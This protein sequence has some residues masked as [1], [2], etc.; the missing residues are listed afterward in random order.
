MSAQ[1][2]VRFVTH[3]A[4]IMALG[5][6]T[7][8]GGCGSARTIVAEAPTVKQS[9]AQATIAEDAATV[10]VPP[11]AKA[12][13]VDAVSKALYAESAF[14]QGQGGVKLSYRFIQFNA[15]SQFERWFWGGIGNAGEGS[16]TVEVRFLDQTGK[17]LA[18][19]QSDGR[20]GSGLF[21]GSMQDAVKRAADEVASYTKANFK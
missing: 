7:A 21:G 11:E 4:T 8:L 17:Q 18:K 10:P 9:F 19:I 2:V 6:L 13:F 20:I 15:G 16:L 3:L 14:T 1:G 5:G 12:A